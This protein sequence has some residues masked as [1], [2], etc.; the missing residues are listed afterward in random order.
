ML[1]APPLVSGPVPAIDI[2]SKS[3]SIVNEAS[4]NSSRLD[5]TQLVQAKDSVRGSTMLMQDHFELYEGS[6]DKE[7]GSIILDESLNGLSPLMKHIAKN[8]TRQNANRADGHFK[9]LLRNPKLNDD[10]PVVGQKYTRSQETIKQQI[11][12]SQDKLQSRF[13]QRGGE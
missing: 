8:I 2:Y 10:F 11:G 1:K 7:K 4:Q 3:I 13:N 9:G 12:L 5:T 6:K